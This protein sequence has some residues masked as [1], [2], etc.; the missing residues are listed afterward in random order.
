LRN[1]R[2]RGENTADPELEVD[3][4]V[5]ALDRLPELATEADN[6]SAVTGAFGIVNARVFF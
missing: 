5:A 3:A 6:L 2:V 1:L 4:A